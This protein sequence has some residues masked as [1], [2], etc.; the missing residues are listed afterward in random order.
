MTGP[1]RLLRAV[2][3]DRPG[4]AAGRRGVL[5][6]RRHFAVKNADTSTAMLADKM[7]RVLDTGAEVCAAAD[8]SCLMH[9]GGGLSRH[10]AGV[11]TMHLAEI[12]AAH[13]EAWPTHE[14]SRHADRAARC[15]PPA[16]R[17]PFPDAARVALADTQLRRNL[18]KATP[19]I[20]AKRGR[21]R[22]RAAR[23]GGAARGRP[24][25]SRPTSCA[26]L[27][28][29][30]AAARGGGQRARRRRALGARRRRGERDRRPD[31]PRPPAP[32]RWSRSS[33]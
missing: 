1:L 23:L 8:T 30:P 12:L 10:G 27:D 9:I 33:R 15:R 24:G 13:P 17:P 22:G 18:G 7:R 20:R 5:R 31:R 4:R 25:A 2:A 32:P 14:R 28:G 16:R 29:L 26:H 3:R 6:L 11:R 21:G 19:T